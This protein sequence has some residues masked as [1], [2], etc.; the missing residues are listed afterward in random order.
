MSRSC[1]QTLDNLTNDVMSVRAYD[2][3]A[4]FPETATT[5]SAPS[6]DTS[7]VQ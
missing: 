4:N 2:K 6:V 1:R 7:S 5:A 3:D